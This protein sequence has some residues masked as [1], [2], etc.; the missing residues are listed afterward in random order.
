MTTSMPS[1]HWLQSE[2]YI[3][4]VCHDGA[5]ALQELTHYP[6]QVVLL[7]IGL[8]SMDG[9]E[10]AKAIRARPETAHVLLLAV[11][12]YGRPEDRDA[13]LRAGFDEHLA[14]PVAIERLLELVCLP[15]TRPFPANQALRGDHGV[16]A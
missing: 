16:D 1:R 3:V 11:T 5:R 4:R 9:Y 8:P 6:A 10:V 14:K 2:G 12:G 15:L 7:D 13:A